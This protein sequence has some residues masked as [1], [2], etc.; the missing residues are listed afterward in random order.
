MQALKLAFCGGNHSK[1]KA[2]P[3]SGKKSNSSGVLPH[4]QS[5]QDVFLSRK[6]EREIQ[7][8]CKKAERQTKSLNA[9]LTKAESKIQTQLGKAKSID[10]IL[11][12][13]LTTLPS[14]EELL[15]ELEQLDK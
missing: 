15:A 5:N 1:P 7:K 14:D 10:E 12:R 11:A 9:K 4:S 2:E 6:E 3:S 13:P 8:L